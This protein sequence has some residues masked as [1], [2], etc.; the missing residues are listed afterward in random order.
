MSHVLVLGRQS[1][2]WNGNNRVNISRLFPDYTEQYVLIVSNYWKNYQ[3][4]TRKRRSPSLP[5]DVFFLSRKLKNNR[6]KI[7]EKKAY[8]LALPMSFY[9]TLENVFIKWNEKNRSRCLIGQRPY[10]VIILIPVL[11]NVPYE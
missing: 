5:N 10:T 3:E 11:D 1:A 7:N 2:T 4:R 8:K 9:P 6:M